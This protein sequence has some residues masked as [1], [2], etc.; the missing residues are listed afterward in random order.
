MEVKVKVMMI[1]EGDDCALQIEPENE[2]GRALLA[3]FGVRGTF[4]TRLGSAT[5]PVELSVTQLVEGYEG[6]PAEL[7]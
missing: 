7:D 2:E 4:R 3:A 1:V 5:G 6:A